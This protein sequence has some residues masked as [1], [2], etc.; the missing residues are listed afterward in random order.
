MLSASGI[1]QFTVH[2]EECQTLLRHLT[3]ALFN[4]T[5]LFVDFFFVHP[6]LMH[7][8]TTSNFVNTGHQFIPMANLFQSP[9]P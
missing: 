6:T 1:G 8:G 7:F 4:T 2:P 9:C 3:S 5:I